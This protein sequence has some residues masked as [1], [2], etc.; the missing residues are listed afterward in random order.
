MSIK[1]IIKEYNDIFNGQPWYGTSLMD[2]LNDI[3]FDEVN[4]KIKNKSHSIAELLKH[5][6]NWRL[7]FIEKLN[8]NKNYKIE[9]DSNADWEKNLIIKDENEWNDLMNELNESQKKLI[10]TLLLKSEDWL[11][12]TTPGE[13]FNNEYL[14][15]GIMDHDVY[16][17]GQIRL[18]H[19]MVKT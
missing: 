11:W 9:N 5:M 10:G 12:E 4:V 16:H 15:K 13:I 14:V 17:L 1:K 8:G 3:S 18:V 2:T 6:L 7:Y 19:K